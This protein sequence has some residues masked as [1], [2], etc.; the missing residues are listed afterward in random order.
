MKA[1]ILI[2]FVLVAQVFA[3]SKSVVYDS[4]DSDEYEAS[5]DSMPIIADSVTKLFSL[6]DSSL[7]QAASDFYSFKMVSSDERGI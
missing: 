1:I 2:L 3:G 6:P 4:V 7:I 5:L